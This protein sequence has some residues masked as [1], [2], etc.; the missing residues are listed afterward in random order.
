[1]ALKIPFSDL[2]K[3]TLPAGF[4]FVGFLGV[5]PGAD[6]YH[7]LRPVPTD[8]AEVFTS[9]AWHD[10]GLLG[11]RE[12]WLYRYCPT[13]RPEAPYPRH[14]DP[15][16]IRASRLRQALVTADEVVRWGRSQGWWLE[17]V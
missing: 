16:M 7:V 11:G 12:G 14:P 17:I 2:V 15:M 9:W 4:G 8:Q 10:S 13:Y 1:M 6:D 3:A 5:S